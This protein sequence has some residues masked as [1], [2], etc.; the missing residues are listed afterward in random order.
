[1]DN[2]SKPRSCGTCVACCV[3][4]SISEGGLSKLA[5]APCPNLVDYQDLIPPVNDGGEDSAKAGMPMFQS[6]HYR[7]PD[8]N[9]CTIYEK[10][11]ECCFDYR[12]A[13]LDGY[14]ET[15]DRPDRSGVVMDKINQ[16]GPIGNAF[17]A[18]PLWFDADVEQAGGTA[19]KN[20]SRD[21]GLPVIVLQFTE[22][23]VLRV[24]GR[25]AK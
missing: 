10:R 21:S 7:G 20:V 17:I 2:G 18:K 9:N 6:K 23:K 16:T 5:L 3:Y 11:P 14:G 25:G 22:F 1:M 19:I 4:P 8:H 12:C 24:V 15:K 13:W